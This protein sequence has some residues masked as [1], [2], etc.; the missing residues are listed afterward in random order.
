V[1]LLLHAKDARA[2]LLPFLDVA[3]VRDERL[4]HLVHALTS[5]PEA[6]A[7]AL[8]PDLPDDEARGVLAALLVEDRKP[9][10]R[11]A[12]VGQFRIHLEREQRLKRQREL[13]RTIA[14]TQATAGGAS[15]VHDDIRALYDESK[16]VYEMTRV[17]AQP[18]E[19]RPRGP[20]GVETNE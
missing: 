18:L 3:D 6:D 4:R 8:M 17:A 5:R 14:E 16:I 9:E 12:L 20:Q 19:H 15:A 11:A 13:A 2:E 1:N 10:D 7:E